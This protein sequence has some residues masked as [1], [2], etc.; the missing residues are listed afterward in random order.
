MQQ[1]PKL[2]LRLPAAGHHDFGDLVKTLL[3]LGAGTGGTLVANKMAR[4]LDPREWR[5]VVVDRDQRHL[6]QPGLLFIP[7]GWYSEA[8]VVKPRQPLLSRRV[9]LILARVEEIQPEISR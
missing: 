1:L 4:R 6:Y 9:K 3:I 2:H 7:F 5:I 8:E